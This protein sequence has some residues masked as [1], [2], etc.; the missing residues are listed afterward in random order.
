MLWYIF[1]LAIAVALSVFPVLAAVLLLRAPDPMRASVGYASGWSLGIIALVSAFAVFARMIPDDVSEPMPPWVHYVGIVVGAFLIVEGLVTA[2]HELRSTTTTAPPKW[3]QRASGLRARRA[4]A[5]G[6]IMNV[7]PKNLALTLAAGLAIG[8]APITL[9]GGGVSVLV[10]AVVG[11]SSVAGLVLAY[12]LAP[13][14]VRPL[15]RVLDAWLVSNA[16]VV[17]RF[18]IVVIGVLLM[19]I[20]ITALTGG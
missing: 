2:V 1:P 14:R 8:A 10:F 12:V 17:L 6:V 20:G 15:L 11:A 16:S 18:S 7:R 5:F 19:T 4:F 9:F 3:L 13:Q